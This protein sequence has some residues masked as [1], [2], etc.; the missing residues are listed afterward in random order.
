MSYDTKRRKA[1]RAGDKLRALAWWKR[2]NRA[3]VKLAPCILFTKSHSD[4]Y[5]WSWEIKV[6]KVTAGCFPIAFT[7]AYQQGSLE[8]GA[9]RVA[10]DYANEGKP[11]WR[12]NYIWGVLP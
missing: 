3:P 8:Y 7:G 9:V 4:R 10:Q 1:E 6:N 5:G 11:P 2:T 12:P